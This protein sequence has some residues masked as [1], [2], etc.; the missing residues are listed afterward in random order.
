MTGLLNDMELMI[1]D[2]MQTGFSTGGEAA[3]LRGE[4]LALRCDSMGLHT[5]KNI[6]DQITSE[7]RKRTFLETK[8]DHELMAQLCICLRY[9]ELARLRLQENSIRQRW[10]NELKEGL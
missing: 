2:L 4:E 10:E 7:L 3:R 6:L 8:N 5:A 1:S 9:I